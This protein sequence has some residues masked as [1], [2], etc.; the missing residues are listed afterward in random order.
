MTEKPKN[1]PEQEV[2]QQDSPYTPDELKWIEEQRVEFERLKKIWREEEK[3]GITDETKEAR[4]K[5]F[6]ILKKVKEFK[7]KRDP[8]FA[9]KMR[10]DVETEV[11][12]ENIEVD[13]SDYDFVQNA[14]II[15]NKIVFFGK[16]DGIAQITDSERVYFRG[17][18][19]QEYVAELGGKVLAVY[20]HVNK[21]V[22][23]ESVDPHSTRLNY[24]ELASSE[25]A[26]YSPR[27][28]G[29]KIFYFTVDEDDNHLLL[30]T[31]GN[32]YS[33]RFDHSIK[34]IFDVN[35]EPM[36][37][38][39]NPKNRKDYIVDENN[40]V[41]TFEL[42]Q[43]S[44]VTGSKEVGGLAFVYEQNEDIYLHIYG[45]E[46]KIGAVQAVKHLAV[47]REKNLFGM[48]VKNEWR[49]LRYDLDEEATKIMLLDEVKAG[50]FPWAIEE[51][52]DIK[53]ITDDKAYVLY[54]DGDKI[55]KKVFDI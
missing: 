26:M 43:I 35:G 9:E 4:R 46:I 23:V 10:R 30:D 17:S 39:Y 36:F 15:N 32:N 21:E 44:E 52:Y 37:I 6:E 41:K 5:S 18:N 53:F 51:I 42:E 19:L 47:R 45:D 20:S 49:V 25:N 22:L 50:T 27:A 16:K 28:I 55:K 48:K 7:K 2:S 33:E 31:E 54:K 34:D 14:H 38:L 29:E 13:I 8:A 12:L 3:T 24:K 11:N 40:N 1:I